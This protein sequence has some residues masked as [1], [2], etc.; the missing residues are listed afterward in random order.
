M[1]GFAAD[2]DREHDHMVEALAAD[3][4]DKA[5]NEGVLPGRARRAQDFVDAHCCES[6]AEGAAVDPVA[7][8]H[9]VLRRAGFGERL[10]DLLGGPSGGWMLGHVEMQDTSAVV[11]ANTTKT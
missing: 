9:Q 1:R 7:V 5:L 8:A 4:A 11:C 6:V 3:R 10:D 2:G